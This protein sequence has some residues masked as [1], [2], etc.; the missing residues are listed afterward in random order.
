MII[1]MVNTLLTCVCFYLCLLRG[2]AG[3]SDLRKAEGMRLL[4]QQCLGVQEVLASFLW[5]LPACLL[6]FANIIH[7]S[8][9]GSF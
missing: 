4:R 3:V 2:V 6:I 1:R 9:E 7:A 8:E 5:W